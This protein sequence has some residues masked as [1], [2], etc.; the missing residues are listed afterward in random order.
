MRP[1]AAQQQWAVSLVLCSQ[2]ST[3]VGE[4][5]PAL[6]SSKAAP[7]SA[8]ALRSATRDTKPRA[9]SLPSPMLK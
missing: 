6:T 1:R 4:R 9:P 5:P 3:L 8:A 7:P 2:H